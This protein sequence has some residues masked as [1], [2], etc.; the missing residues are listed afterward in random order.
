M[1]AADSIL[2]ENA[3]LKL[4]D[5]RRNLLCLQEEADMEKR[6]RKDKLKRLE[7]EAIAEENKA[8][9]AKLY[10]QVWVRERERGE[11]EKN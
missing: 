9:Q 2:V 1:S 3:E 8:V 6:R 11:R 7:E 4:E 5:L 10:L